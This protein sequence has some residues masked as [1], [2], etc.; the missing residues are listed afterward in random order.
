MWL[1]TSHLHVVKP[2][3]PEYLFYM[4]CLVGIFPCNKVLKLKHQKSVLLSKL[5]D[6]GV[7]DGGVKRPVEE[8][9]LLISGIH[10]VE[11]PR[12]FLQRSILI[13]MKRSR[14]PIGSRSFVLRVSERCLPKNAGI[15]IFRNL[16]ID[17]SR[18]C[19]W[20]FVLPLGHSVM[21][22][23][24][25][26]RVPQN[27]EDFWSPYANC[28]NSWNDVRG[29]HISGSFLERND[30]RSHHGMIPIAHVF[31]SKITKFR[32]V[33]IGEIY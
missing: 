1:R 7:Q 3:E 13:K 2:G 14:K 8:L 30:I 5:N 22:V 15:N 27:S 17:Q 12:I 21:R 6:P 20:I 31:F 24:T 4:C 18:K 23:R 28:L 10:L 19:R 32:F 33:Y 9:L 16:S 26:D 29:Y 11:K 25:V